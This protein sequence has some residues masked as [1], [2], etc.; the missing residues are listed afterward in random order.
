MLIHQLRMPLSCKEAA[1]F[2]TD[3]VEETMSPKMR[4]KFEKHMAMCPNCEV[5]LE[6]YKHTILLANEAFQGDIEIPDDLIEHTM[7]FMK[8]HIKH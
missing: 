3:Y 2:I 8:E 1:D 7:A 4:K 6:Q 5:Y